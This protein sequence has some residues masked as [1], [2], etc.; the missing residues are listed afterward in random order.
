MNGLTTL[1]SL[2]YM[3]LVVSQGYHMVDHMTDVYHCVQ[4]ITV[5]KIN[6]SM[7]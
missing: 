7:M 2:I 1:M 3:Y 5:I 6:T 4:V